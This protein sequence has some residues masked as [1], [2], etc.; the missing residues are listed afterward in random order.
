MRFKIRINKIYFILCFSL[1]LCGSVAYAFAEGVAMDTV[2]VLI[3]DRVQNLEL[4]PLIDLVIFD[5][6]NKLVNIEPS[7]PIIVRAA[8][9]GFSINNKKVNTSRLKISSATLSGDSNV[10]LIRIGTKKYRGE[11]D[12]VRQGNDIAVIN[13]LNIEE[14]LCGVVPREMPYEWHREALKAQAVAARTYTYN[15]LATINRSARLYDLKAT[16]ADQVYG[17]FNDERS[18]CDSAIYATA[19]EILVYD[20]KPILACYH[21]NSGGALENDTDV[22]RTKM[23]YLKGKSDEFS[24]TGGRYDWS[25]SVTAAEIRTRL[26]SAGLNI[27][28]IRDITLSEVADSGRVRYI[29]II[30]SNGTTRLTGVAFRDKMGTTFI[31]STLFTLDKQENRYIFRGKGNGHGVGMSQWSAYRM[32]QQGMN[33]QE[34]LDYFYPGTNLVKK[35][36]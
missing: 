22:F 6:E 31:R 27:G 17:G 15:K 33:Y 18:S 3:L 14:Y 9:S 13:I 30:H 2:R 8:G 1:W 19:G 32:A 11:L 36:Q 12:L 20:D 26:V 5:S 28:Q 29:T 24:P 4:R 21:G 10:P 35:N 34:I 16:I 7:E 23:P 25:Q